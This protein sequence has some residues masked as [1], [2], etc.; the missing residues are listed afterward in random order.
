MAVAVASLLLLQHGNWKRIGNELLRGSPTVTAPRTSCHGRLAFVF[1]YNTPATSVATR[2]WPFVYCGSVCCLLL[3]ADG[4]SRRVGKV[5]SLNNLKHN[6]PTL[7]FKLELQSTMHSGQRAYLQGAHR[8][9]KV[10]S[11]FGGRLKQPTPHWQ[12]HGRSFMDEAHTASRPT[13]RNRQHQQR[14]RVSSM[15]G[16]ASHGR[17][18]S[19]VELANVRKVVAS[20]LATK[21]CCHG[22]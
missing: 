9:S 8:R 17:D 4:R 19:L 6:K 5:G 18:T 2:L 11:A 20:G 15:A 21:P 7:K 10:H 16:A 12:M 13:P 22:A 1:G 14:T 3:K